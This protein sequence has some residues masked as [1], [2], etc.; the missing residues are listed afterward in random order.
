MISEFSPKIFEG[1][2]IRLG[3]YC[4]KHIFVD[5]PLTFRVKEVMQKANLFLFKSVCI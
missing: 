2:I 1:M 4:I 5:A 3:Y